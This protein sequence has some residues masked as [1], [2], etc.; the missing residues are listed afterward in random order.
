M[1]LEHL[2]CL[3][4]VRAS[5]STTQ[6]TKTAASSGARTPRRVLSP[7][8][9]RVGHYSGTRPFTPRVNVFITS[10]A[11]VPRMKPRLQQSFVTILKGRASLARPLLRVCP[12]G[13]GTGRPKSCL[14][15]SPPFTPKIPP[16]IIQSGRLLLILESQRT[17][18]PSPG[19][20]VRC[21]S[22]GRQSRAPG[23]CPG[24]VWSALSGPGVSDDCH[25]NRRVRAVC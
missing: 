9:Q 10:S 19:G 6:D 16:R 21:W 5:T 15:A 11:A 17:K 23:R 12:I 20:F 1:R 7:R 25:E 22:I 18:P 13:S 3:P 14:V 8:D 24:L 4:S 2:T